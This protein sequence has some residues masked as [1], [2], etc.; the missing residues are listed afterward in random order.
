MGQAA[1]DSLEGFGFMVRSQKAR[2]PSAR[3]DIGIFS[4]CR[5]TLPEQISSMR[6][7][8]KASAFVQYADV[9]SLFYVQCP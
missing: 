9:A 5:L 1:C 8:L 4:L 2:N 6:V 3:M 7:Q